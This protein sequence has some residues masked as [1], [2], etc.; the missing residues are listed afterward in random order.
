MTIIEFSIGGVFIAIT[1]YLGYKLK[2]TN[3]KL[4]S[5]QEAIDQA[6]NEFN[7]LCSLQ[8][9]FGERLLDAETSIKKLIA[10]RQSIQNPVASPQSLFTQA[11]KLLMLGA[12]LDD[13]EKT[14]GLSKSEAKLIA[15]TFD[16][17]LDTSS[18]ERA[19]TLPNS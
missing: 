10:Q 16:L 13:V 3:K 2:N 5:Q 7:A 19:D 9:G 6:L 17:S 8:H 14:C 4:A 18:A 11:K 1:G 15:M 12:S